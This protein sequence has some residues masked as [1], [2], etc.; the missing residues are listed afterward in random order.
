MVRGRRRNVR[1]VLSVS[2]LGRW[3]RGWFWEVDFGR[4]VLGGWFWE[5]SFGRSV[6]QNVRLSREEPSDWLMGSCA[7]VAARPTHRR[8]RSEPVTFYLKPH[9]TNGQVSLL[10]GMSNP[11]GTTSDRSE[12]SREGTT[13]DRSEASREGTTSDRSKPP[14]NG[15]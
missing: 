1:R 13:S 7:A 14:P 3:P 4:L 8:T 11:E 15:R 5:V 12:A 6:F 2:R 10:L 9:L